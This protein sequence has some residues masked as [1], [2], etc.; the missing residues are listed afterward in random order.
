MTTTT[1][2]V[3]MLFNVSMAAA[4][5]AASLPRGV[6]CGESSSRK[7]DNEMLQQAKSLSHK[8]TSCRKRPWNKSI[9]DA[10]TQNLLLPLDGCSS[11]AACPAPVLSVRYAQ[12]T[13]VFRAAVSMGLHP[14]VRS[15]NNLVVAGRTPERQPSTYC[16]PI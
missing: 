1:R 7:S 10:A 6:C 16:Q 11:F 14:G 13:T 8:L 2:Y 5:P 4:V 3:M 12:Q 9:T 15:R